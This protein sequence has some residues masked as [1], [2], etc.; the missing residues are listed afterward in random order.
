[1]KACI[2]VV[3]AIAGSLA[4]CTS[5]SAWQ[6]DKNVA[7]ISYEA[8]ENGLDRTIGKL[9]RLAILPG[10]FEVTRD[11]EAAG[12]E[13]LR[14]SFV[15]S[16]TEFLEGERGYSVIAL[17]PETIEELSDV[18]LDQLLK[19]CAASVAGWE[20]DGGADPPEQCAS[21][22]G[23]QLGVDGV[24]VVSGSRVSGRQW[25]FMATL[26]T[27]SLAWPL[28]MSQEQIEASAVLFEVSSGDTVWRSRFSKSAAESSGVSAALAVG[29]LFE[30]LEHALP[31]ALTQ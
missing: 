13:F 2:P 18:E 20:E 19:E 26:L 30:G 3:L 23:R 1:M 7:P 29:F 27:A 25:R 31:E 8:T 11:G 6:A 17:T 21:R 22:I 5:K 4:A 28:L 12:A 24:F 16:T 15:R 10:A 9:R 14:A